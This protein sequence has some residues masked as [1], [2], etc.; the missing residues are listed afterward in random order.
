MAFSCGYF[1]HFFDGMDDKWCSK[2]HCSVLEPPFLYPPDRQTWHTNKQI[3][4][5]DMRGPFNH[6]ATG[7]AHTKRIHALFSMTSLSREP[8]VGTIPDI[9]Q[10]PHHEIVIHVFSINKHLASNSVLLGNSGRFI[11]LPFSKRFHKMS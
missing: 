4:R 11:K 7:I 3:K 10:S 6:F 8:Q 9:N 1:L 5:E 2:Y